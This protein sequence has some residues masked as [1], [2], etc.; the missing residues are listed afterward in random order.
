MTSAA[1]FL[2]L[3]QQKSFRPQ[4]PFHDFDTNAFGALNVLEAARRWT[5]EI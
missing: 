3:G 5:P 1:L 4:I 2:L